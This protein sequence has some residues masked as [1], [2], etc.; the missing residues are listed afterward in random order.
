MPSTPSHTPQLPLLPEF[1]FCVADFQRS[2]VNNPQRAHH[3]TILSFFSQMR[4]KQIGIF[5]TAM[6]GLLVDDFAG[7]HVLKCRKDLPVQ[8]RL[9]PLVIYQLGGT[10]AY[11]HGEA[12]N[13]C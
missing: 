8:R 12:M 1:V 13:E 2:T 11:N 4:Y 7:W 9:A 6:A 10:D 3:R 5:L